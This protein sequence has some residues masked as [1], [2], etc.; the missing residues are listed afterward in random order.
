M[1]VLSDELRLL[2]VRVGVLLVTAALAVG[3]L[4]AATVADATHKHT[5]HQYAH[6]IGDFGDADAFVHPFLAS[7]NGTSRDT[8]VAYG[9][10]CGQPYW[11]SSPEQHDNDTHNHLNIYTGSVPERH[12]FASVRVPQTGM[13]HHH[14]TCGDG[15]CYMASGSGEE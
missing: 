8:Y 13:D 9:Y 15:D 1:D 14:H 5:T 10:C 11:H 6:G 7:T 3:S 4:I 2:P 12:T